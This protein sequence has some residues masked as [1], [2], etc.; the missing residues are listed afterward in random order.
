MKRILI[1]VLT[2]LLAVGCVIPSFAAEKASSGDWQYTV[3]NGEAV[4]TCNSSIIRFNT[5]STQLRFRYTVPTSTTQ[6]LV[7]LYKLV[8]NG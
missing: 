8:E 2:L 6:P 4:I 3:R 7:Q 1:L 5:Y